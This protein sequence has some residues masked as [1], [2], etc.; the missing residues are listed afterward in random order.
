MGQLRTA[1]TNTKTQQRLSQPEHN[2][3]AGPEHYNGDSR[4]FMASEVAMAYDS[5]IPNSQGVCLPNTSVTTSVAIPFNKTPDSLAVSGLYGCTSLVVVS[6]KG[7]YVNH[8]WECP[9]FAPR[10]P[11]PPSDAGENSSFERAVLDIIKYGS[12]SQYSPVGLCFAQTEQDLKAPINILSLFSKDSHPRVFLFAPWAIREP[13]RSDG[14][15]SIS[16]PLTMRYEGCN[17]QIEGAVKESFKSALPP[18][19][20]IPYEPRVLQPETVIPDPEER[21]R[22]VGDS[23]FESHEG[24]VLVQYK[25][26]ADAKGKATLRVWFEARLEYEEEWSPAG[27]FQIA[28]PLPVDPQPVIRPNSRRSHDGVG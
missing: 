11:P 26:A 1:E 17:R 22:E 27:E 28:E 9:H 20:V 23:N 5:K 16:G 18:F 7:A 3:L 10:I 24:K 14:T 12:R 2:G 4:V 25:P 13:P 19:K 6:K 21:Q 15:Q 8:M